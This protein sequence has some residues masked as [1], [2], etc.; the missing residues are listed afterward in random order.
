MT[1]V[2]VI[3]YETRD[4]PSLNALMSRNKAYCVKNRIEYLRFG[5]IQDIPTYWVKVNLVLMVLRGAADGDIVCWLDSDATIVD[6]QTHMADLFRDAGPGKY[7][8]ASRD[9]KPYKS[10][11]NAGVFVV[12]A[13]GVSRRLMED[14]MDL[15]RP[16]RWTQLA[17]GTWKCSGTWAGE[18]YEQGSFCKHILTKHA[19]AIKIFDADKFDC[20]TPAFAD[21][22]PNGGRVFSCHFAGDYKVRIPDLIADGGRGTGKVRPVKLKEDEEFFT[23]RNI[24]FVVAGALVG[25]LAIWA[26]TKKDVRSPAAALVTSL[27]DSIKR[28]L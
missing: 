12:K 26:F 17:D 21:L 9:P 28:V 19:H 16:D 1:Q 24:S 15:Y 27:V 13:N 5:P 14:W 11:F 2:T 8:L 4:D 6:Q 10:P 23:D 3:Q 18:D 25:A 22:R 20:I 7:F